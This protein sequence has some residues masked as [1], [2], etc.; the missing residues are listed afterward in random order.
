MEITLVKNEDNL[1]EIEFKDVDVSVVNLIKDRLVNRGD[2]EFAA[3]IREHITVSPPKLVLR[4]KKN[5]KT[6]IREAIKS[7]MKDLNKIEKKLS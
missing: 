2:V 5:P 7:I 4:T 1:Y 6:L 3:S